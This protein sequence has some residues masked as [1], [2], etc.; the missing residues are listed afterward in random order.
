VLRRFFDACP[1]GDYAFAELSA[2]PARFRH[3]P[4]LESTMQRAC[5]CTAAV[6][7][8][9]LLIGCGQITV[10]AETDLAA[11]LPP[12]PDVPPDVPEDVPI[13]PDVDAT[14][15]TDA[16]ID[17]LTVD[18]VSSDVPGT[19][20]ETA[21][22]CTDQVKGKTP[23]ILPACDN[24]YC[25]KKQKPAG[26]TCVDPE[27]KPGECSATICSPTGQCVLQN[28]PDK[29][30]NVVTVCGISECGQKCVDGACVAANEADYEDGNPCT[31]DI[32]NQG[33]EI[34]HVPITDFT[35]ECD[36]KDACTTG[37]VCLQGECKGK[38][39]DCSDGIA[40]TLDTCDAATGCISSGDGT[41]C[42]D[43][44]PCT[45]DA[46]DLAVGCT[47]DGA[48]AGAACN[49]KNKC[50]ENDMCAADGSCSGTSICMCQQ[51]VDCTSA[52]KCLGQQVC[53]KN[54]C[55]ID[56]AAA[57]K[58]DP[59]FD[60]FCLQD[61]CEPDTGVC[62]PKP[63]HDSDPCEDGNACTATTKCNA[64]MCL[65]PSD[66]VC[67]DTNPCTSD[68][69]DPISGCVYTPNT[70]TC[71]DGNQCTQGDLCAKGACGGTAI[72]CDDNLACTLDGCETTTGICTHAGNATACDDGNP[73]SSDS[74][75]TTTGCKHGADDAGKCDDGNACTVDTCKGGTC[76]A[77]NTCQCQVASQTVDCN[78]NNPCTA[79][80]CDP[81]AHKCAYATAP[82]DGNTCNPS[83]KCLVANTGVCAGGGCTGGKPVDCAASGD[84]CNA[85]TCNP[86]TGGCLA[87]A[88]P[89]GTG[90]D[91]DQNGCTIGDA[92]QAGK[93]LAGTTADCSASADACNGATCQSSGSASYTCVKAPKPPATGCDD[94]KFCTT[95][96]HC[97]GAGACV[98]PNIKT[99]G[100][101]YDACNTGLCDES[102]KQCVK[103]PKSSTVP[104]N[105]GLYC[106][107]GDHCDGAGTCTGGAAVSCPGGNCL[108]GVCD[109]ANDKCATATAPATTS[110]DD[111]DAC[112]TG[113]TCNVTGLCQGGAQKACPSDACNDATCD[114]VSAA[115]GVKAKAEGTG[116][117]DKD[118]CTSADKCSAG[119]CKP[120]TYTCKC[121]ATTQ[122]ADCND[123]NVCTTDTCVA[124]DGLWV[125]KNQGAAGLSCSDGNACTLGDVCTALGTCTPGGAKTCAGNVCNDGVCDTGN[126]NCSLQPKTVTTACDDANACTTGDQC[127]NGVCKSGSYTCACTVES[128][129]TACNDN[130][131]CT[132]DVCVFQTGSGLWACK[133][134]VTPAIGCD[135][136]NACTKSDTC[137]GNAACIGAAVDCNDNNPCTDDSCNTTSGCVHAANTAPCD[138]GDACTTGDTCAANACK[139]GTWTCECKV[140]SQVAD[141]NDGNTCTV[142]TCV[143][144]G[145]LYVCAHT[146]QTGQSCDDLDPCSIVSQCSST[147]TCI[148]SAWFDC[149][150]TKDQ[151]NSAACYN[152]FGSAACKKVPTPTI[153]CNDGLAC[154][155]NDACDNAGKC[156][157]G[158]SPVCPAAPVC[159]DAICSEPSGCTTAPTPAGASCSD[160]DPCSAG[161][162]CNGTGVCSSGL[163]VADFT[164]C[165][166][167]SAGT[168]ADVCIAGKCAGFTLST[169]PLGPATGIAWQPKPSSWLVTASDTPMSSLTVK[170]GWSIWGLTASASG[171]FAM[172]PMF[173][174]VTTPLRAVTGQVAVGQANAVVTSPGNGAW[175][176]AG[177][178]LATA[179]AAAGVSA[180]WYGVDQRTISGVMFVQ[181]V[182]A[183][184][185]SQLA[186][187][188]SGPSDMSGTW[189]CAKNSLGLGVA[190]SSAM[191][192]FD[193]G[194]SPVPCP[195]SPQ[196]TVAALQKFGTTQYSQ[197]VSYA[198]SPPNSY[199]ASLAPYFATTPYP[200]QIVGSTYLYDT[201]I[202]PPSADSSQMWMVGPAGHVSYQ[203]KGG[204]GLAVA[205][206]ITTYPQQNYVFSAVTLSPTGNV[207]IWGSRPLD[208]VTMSKTVPVLF[209]H[210]DTAGQQ[211]GAKYW[212]ELELAQAPYNADF[213]T[214]GSGV[215][216]TGMGLA[217]D[218]TIAL[219]GNYCGN[220]VA[221][222]TIYLKAMLYARQPK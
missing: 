126:G 161:D 104:C 174:A 61:T 158:P 189:T 4:A 38:P 123:S 218:G 141:C 30:G 112:T 29:T 64:G 212:Q 125:C 83:D 50:T 197:M 111:S 84:A 79:D 115:C 178:P 37:D 98:G 204:I 65:G 51:D 183:V 106:T 147:A 78:D 219:L 17:V 207:L 21:F 73:C 66:V 138:D 5:S 94:G 140:A 33:I 77:V 130:N 154:T 150:G 92:C 108:V 49:D 75:D 211:S 14:P 129:S 57:V 105:D 159:R 173:G 69:C 117:D 170:S 7:A 47:V 121:K 142:E 176:F 187:R 12:A 198:F 165:D 203:A 177:G 39:K 85:G 191:A 145:N 182:G 67:D 97:D 10:Q 169:G 166:D 215:M 164:P 205:T 80:T 206:L 31:K 23:C 11:D 152:S 195:P 90:C 8:T 151:C 116:C 157:G 9:L 143:K 101:M 220:T 184:G 41:K 132:S 214:S 46:C 192:L 16:E 74:C 180:D 137:D 81:V 103:V 200:S 45:K 3:R 86:S 168:S 193:A 28:K 136:K 102:Q 127:Q 72:S 52:N 1:L 6:V 175:S 48:V 133:N 56:P 15:G 34:Q 36:D 134:N 179:L 149:S 68:S 120:G 167:S 119:V 146:A 172:E 40:C 208:G 2:P 122:A 27:L 89:D 201:S 199:G 221:S 196:Y 95:G 55:V 88:K 96:D 44:D 99:C 171:G 109:E 70:L 131:A 100:A 53:V 222:P 162:S 107:S 59:T 20:C 22:D 42:N 110:C 124:S 185:T 163:K 181:L 26:E 58:C 144:S 156:L 76:T 35:K 155:T 217:P 82:V 202:I 113:E 93:C 24:G 139:A 54:V 186:V 62:A 32:C 213:C 71:D 194:C 153:A 91:Y 188:C 118:L 87:I 190:V 160:G 210:A 216:T 18:E 135:D 43:G 148:A 60:T 114:P 25:V 63:V 209:V 128:Q 19:D 13:S